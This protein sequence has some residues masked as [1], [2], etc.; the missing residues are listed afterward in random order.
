MIKTRIFP[1]LCCAL[2]L[3]GCG[4]QAEPPEDSP[5]GDTVAQTPEI[6]IPAVTLDQVSFDDEDADTGWQGDS[7]R[8]ITLNGDTIAYEGSGAEV[9]GGTITVTEP[10]TYLVSGSLDD[11]T[12][13]VDAGSNDVIRLVL[14]GADIHCSDG[15][16]IYVKATGKAILTLADGTENSVSDGESYSDTGDDA[17]NA[18]IFS[19]EDMIIN[20]NGTLTVHGNYDNAVTGRDDLKIL[21]GTLYLYA[22]DDGLMGRDMV[23]VRDGSLTIETGGDGIKAT[24][25]DDGKG[26]VAIRSGTFAITAGTDGIQAQSAVLVEGGTFT[27]TTG[28]GSANGSAGGGDTMGAGGQPWGEWGNGSGSTEE[29]EDTSSAKG[30]KAGANI[31][32]TGGEFTMDTSDDAIHSNTDITIDDGIYAIASGDDGIHADSSLLINGGDMD[33]SQSY[34][35]LESAVVTVAAGNIRINAKDDGVNVAGGN[36][37]SSINGRPGQNGFT[38]NANQTLNISGGY[39]YVQAAGDGLDSNGSMTMTD[40]T[41]IVNGPTDNGNG[42]LDYNGTCEVSGGILIAAGSAGMAQAP[43]EDSAQ[44]A[45]LMQYDTVRQAGDLIRIEDSEGSDIL[46]FAPAKE[47]QSLLLCSPS[48]AKGETYTLYAGGAA[49]GSAA[50]GLYQGGTYTDGTKIT[51]FTISDRITYLNESGVTTGAGQGPG[52]P[53]QGQGGPMDQGGRR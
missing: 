42:S 23:T 9:N 19:K 46:T 1:I 11:G 28:G 33:I 21:G 48:L 52:G 27:M 41:V 12:I 6:A 3:A 36:D 24:N 7:V 14:G 40:G 5:S 50:D 20:G 18:A 47:Y 49:T 45:V 32:I 38:A 16:A 8:E 22:A 34:E 43:G 37:G 15:A 51:E 10:G 4:R 35:G 31:S 39:V 13:I 29:E 44:Y 2:L 25:T 17:P 26:Y 53:G 30:V